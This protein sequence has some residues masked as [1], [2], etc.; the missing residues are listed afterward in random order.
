MLPPALRYP[1]FCNGLQVVFFSAFCNSHSYSWINI[2]C[3]YGNYAYTP[4]S[5]RQSHN[6]IMLTSSKGI[7][8]FSSPRPVV[9]NNSG[10]RIRSRH[11]RSGIARCSLAVIDGGSSYAPP[12]KCVF[13]T[14]G[15]V[16]GGCLSRYGLYLPL[17][18]QGI[19]ANRPP[20]IS[21]AVVSTSH[22]PTRSG[23]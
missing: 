1:S 6:H 8:T 20:W 2:M 16:L 3:Y 21:V 14:G 18:P 4:I 11:I 9:C 12:L 7:L 15:Q 5:L 13:F 22:P 17:A 19:R 23:F 10:I